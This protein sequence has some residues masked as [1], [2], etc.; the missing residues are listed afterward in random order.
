MDIGGVESCVPTV[1]RETV[2]EKVRARKKENV[3]WHIN[4]TPAGTLTFGT[5]GIGMSF[6]ELYRVGSGAAWPLY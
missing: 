6:G 2:Q 5:A 4:A 1:I 3:C